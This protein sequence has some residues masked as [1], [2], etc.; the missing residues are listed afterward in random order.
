LNA[1]PRHFLY[2]ICLWLSA[3]TV[4]AHAVAPVGSPIAKRSGSAFSA[5]TFEV[6]LIPTRAWPAKAMPVLD[7]GPGG[8]DSAGANPGPSAILAALPLTVATAVSAQRVEGLPRDPFP[9]SLARAGFRA[10]APPAA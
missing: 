6:S 8:N 10:R 1:T 7:A 9:P 5:S 3:F 2:L 4:A